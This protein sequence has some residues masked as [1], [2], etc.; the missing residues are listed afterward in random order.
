MG[1]VTVV[2][3]VESLAMM[4]IHFGVGDVSPISFRQVGGRAQRV[5]AR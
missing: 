5:H 4:T 2:V 1:V 3:V